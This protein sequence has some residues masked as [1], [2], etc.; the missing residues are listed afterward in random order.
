MFSHTM[1]GRSRRNLGSYCAPRRS[2][3]A[4]SHVILEASFN[5][6]YNPSLYRNSWSFL[7]VLAKMTMGQLRS[8]LRQGTWCAR[9][10]HI[11]LAL[12]YLS[13][14]CKWTYTLLDLFL[15]S[16][17]HNKCI[18]SRSWMHMAVRGHLQYSMKQPYFPVLHNHSCI[19]KRNGLP[20]PRCICRT[21]TLCIGLNRGGHQVAT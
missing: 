17:N 14:L 15:D 4:S 19:R 16:Q 18:W 20:C 21:R 10:G 2:C 7:P 12:Y 5:E 11:N 6:S 8:Y 13:N 3:T 9:I 1:F